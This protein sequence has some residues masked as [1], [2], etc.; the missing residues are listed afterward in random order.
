MSMLQLINFE[1]DVA[2]LSHPQRNNE[3]QIGS[4]YSDS[5]EYIKVDDA[6]FQHRNGCNE[7][8]TSMLYQTVGVAIL[9]LIVTVVLLVGP[10]QNVYSGPIGSIQFDEGSCLIG[11]RDGSVNCSLAELRCAEYNGTDTRFLGWGSYGGSLRNCGIEFCRGEN[12][13]PGFYTGVRI[14]YPVKDNPP[15]QTGNN[16]MIDPLI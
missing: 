11:A 15:E 6:K 7:E 4:K 14:C 1:W 9:Y 5:I 8:E 3:S 10:V 2:R 12:L 13:V 16:M